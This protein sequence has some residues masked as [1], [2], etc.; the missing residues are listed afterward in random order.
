MWH[1]H[2]RASQWL[3]TQL[4]QNK[5]NELQRPQALVRLEHLRKRL[6]AFI[7]DLVAREAVVVA[8]QQERVSALTDHH[9]KQHTKHTYSS[10]CRHWFTSSA[11]VSARAPS[12]SILLSRRLLMRWHHRSEGQCLTEPYQSKEPLTY[13]NVCR[14][15]FTLSPSAIARAPSAPILLSPRLL[16]L[17]HHMKHSKVSVSPIYH[18]NDEPHEPQVLQDLVHHERLRHRPRAFSADLVVPKAVIVVPPHERREVSISPIYHKN[19][20]PHEPQVLQVLVHLER[21]RQRPCA[22]SA[23]LVVH[24]A[25]NLYTRTPRGQCL[26]DQS[27]KTTRSHTNFSFWRLRFTLSPSASARAPSAPM[28]FSSRLSG[29]SAGEQGKLG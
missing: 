22:F 21:L 10:D 20:E 13:L 26:T 25:V 27:I 23:D 11:C 5:D 17:W 28:L 14:L 15:W 7:A 4:R 1:H 18:K 16:L 2:T 6:R 3:S 9:H 24:E 8:P 19:D 29:A 12:A